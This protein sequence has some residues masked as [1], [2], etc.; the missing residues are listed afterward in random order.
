MSSR[1]GKISKTR[2]EPLSRGGNDINERCIDSTAAASWIETTGKNRQN[3]VQSINFGPLCYLQLRTNPRPQQLRAS[4]CN[5]QLAR[6]LD[7][8]LEDDS[9]SL[10]PHLRLQRLTG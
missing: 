5:T 6:L 4:P 2:S 9:V 1:S 10:L 7:L 8:R 3:N